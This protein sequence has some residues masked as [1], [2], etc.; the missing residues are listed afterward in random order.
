[1]DRTS[2]G[3]RFSV[4]T[5]MRWDDGGR[6]L[7]DRNTIV[8]LGSSSFVAETAEVEG[9]G[10]FRM[11]GRNEVSGA[12]EIEGQVNTSTESTFELAPSAYLALHGGGDNRGDYL[13]GTGADLGL[14]SGTYV[15]RA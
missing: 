5:G 10:L 15:W 7:T 9:W 13:L 3:R 11:T 4:P 6:F 2:V 14:W 8:E 1:G 12:L